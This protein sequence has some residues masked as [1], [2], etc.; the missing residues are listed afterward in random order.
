M[1]GIIGVNI[2]D[3]ITNKYFIPQEHLNLEILQKEEVRW[4]LK[5]K[6]NVL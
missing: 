1:F 2:F 6:L 5:N 4:N 3:I